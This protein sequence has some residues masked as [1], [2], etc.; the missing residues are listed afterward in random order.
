[1]IRESRNPPQ[2][3]RSQSQRHSIS[4]ISLYKLERLTAWRWKGGGSSRAGGYVPYRLTLPSDLNRV[5]LRRVEHDIVNSHALV[6][7]SCPSVAAG[8][9]WLRLTVVF[10]TG[11]R[12]AFFIA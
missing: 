4:V 11:N 12:L 9:M 2:S 5:G 6:P 10:D 8:S 7:L 3:M 1:M